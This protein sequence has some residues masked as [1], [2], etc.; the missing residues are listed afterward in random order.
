M[1]HKLQV[2][3]YEVSVMQSATID[4]P[5]ISIRCGGQ[6]VQFSSVDRWQKVKYQIDKMIEDLEHE[7]VIQD[8]SCKV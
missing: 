7:K 6:F 5:R 8:K 1:E 3:G 2:E 4:N